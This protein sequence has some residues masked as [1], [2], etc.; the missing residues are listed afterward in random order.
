MNESKACSTVTFK[1][2]LQSVVGSISE[3]KHFLASI[4]DPFALD[5]MHQLGFEMITSIQQQEYQDAALHC[6]FAYKDD[7]P[8]GT[9]IDFQGKER[10][11]CR[12]INVSC[13]RFSKCRPDFN[14]EELKILEENSVLK[15]KQSPSIII[16]DNTENAGDSVA[17]KKVLNQ[18]ANLTVNQTIEAMDE[19]HNKTS[20]PSEG[21]DN[22]SGCLQVA[23]IQE[24]VRSFASFKDAEQID[25]IHLAPE[26]RTIVNA[27]PGTGKTWTLIEKIKFMLTEK[28]VAPEKI[29]VLC[30]S[31]AAVEVIRTRLE[32]AASKGELPL[33]WHEIDIRTFDSFATYLL[34]WL[35]EEKP[36]LLPSGFSLENS[37]YDDRIVAA[38]KAITQFTDML[39]EYS[40]L[41]IDEVQDLVGLRAQMVL[42][43]LKNLPETCGF[44]LLGDSCQSL[45][46]YLAV[47][48]SSIMDSGSFYKT[49]FATYNNAHYF[50]LT[51]NYR[52]G[53][54]LG[55]FTIPYRG[56]I[57]QGNADDRIREAKN[58]ISTLNISNLDLKNIDFSS[59]DKLTKR[60][61][62]G[63]LTRTN[64]QALQISSWFRSQG[65]TH[66][67][68]KPLS[69]QELAPWIAR[70]LFRC[71]TD[72]INRNEFVSIFTDIYSDAGDVADNYWN[73]LIS[74]QADQFKR[75]YDIEDILKGLLQNA[76]NPILFKEPDKAESNITISNIHRAKG[77]EFDSVLVL[78]EILEEMA[79]EDNDD[80][81]EH[82]VCYVALTRAKKKV[83]T[84][85]LKSKFIYI[86][87]DENRRCF[88]SNGRPGHYYLSHFEIGDAADIDKRTFAVDKNVQ[89][90]ILALKPDTRLKF[91]RCPE[92]TRSYVVYRIVPEDEEKTVLG[93]S[94]PAF[95]RA[96]EKAVQRIYKNN[97]TVSYNYYPEIFEDIYFNGLTTCISSSCT[98]I[99]DANIIGGMAMWYGIDLSGF[100]HRQSTRY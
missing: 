27:G 25:I 49:L 42:A 55:K 43:I 51:H 69:S 22:N 66:V 100:A 81:L 34:A 11:V 65:I 97:R 47:N 30:F 78:D 88:M 62:V 24:S 53:D 35:H 59:L 19:S 76:K 79:K 68:E 50:T 33:D 58:I 12:C 86:S 57:L 5:T 83:E 96:I 29:L 39:V 90:K 37:G 60:G 32:D 85:K 64:G 48:D 56:A 70:V 67:I 26:E 6:S 9:V 73:A 1:S 14:A 61:T 93:Y 71:Q 10:V 87:K 28:G 40:H 2:N 84:I 41:I 72:V 74:T 46:D 3:D 17:V 16:E 91:L 95:A 21:N 99:D 7:Y 94:T 98:G 82:K 13:T 44:T 54:E 92:S 8:W 20:V 31:R 18:P 89:E 15:E 4:H 75:Y 23:G 36:E 80:I 77:R 63:I 45:Y 38:T 52:Q